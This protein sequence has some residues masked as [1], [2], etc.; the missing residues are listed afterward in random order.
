MEDLANV[1]ETN[2]LW[3]VYLFSLGVA[4]H[5]V[6]Q[7][8]VIVLT[9]LLPP[10]LSLSLSLSLSSLRSPCRQALYGAPPEGSSL[11]PPAHAEDLCADSSVDA[12][13]V[14]STEVVGPSQRSVFTKETLVFKGDFF[15]KLTRS[16]NRIDRD[17]PQLIGDRWC[18]VPGDLDAT[19]RIDQTDSTYFFK[20]RIF[21]G[22]HGS[23]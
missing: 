21:P 16:G 11:V 13:L 3:Y 4:S 14:A 12:T 10:S 7:V 18:G 20:V 2:I 23:L 8:E 19:L 15:W 9:L 1:T 6:C 5:T 22:V 17:Y